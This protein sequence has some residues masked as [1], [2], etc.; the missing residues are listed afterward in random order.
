M[1][2]SRP[3]R[4]VNRSVY[5]QSAEAERGLF[6]NG[7]RSST[8]GTKA[9]NQTGSGLIHSIVKEQ[10]LPGQLEGQQTITECT[11]LAPKVKRELNLV[12]LQFAVVHLPRKAEEGFIAQAPSDGKRTSTA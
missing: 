3:E 8:P 5:P 11:P 6:S 9:K 10:E 1:K 4:T 2:L 7:L 12:A